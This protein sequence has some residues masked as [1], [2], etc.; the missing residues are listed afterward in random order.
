VYAT[1]LTQALKQVHPE[2]LTSQGNSVVPLLVTLDNLRGATTGRV[3][4]S[5]PVGA[6]VVVA[7][8]FTQFDSNWVW[9]FSVAE[10]ESIQSRIYVRLPENVTQSD[11]SIH[12]ATDIEGQY[13][14]QVGDQLSLA[15]EADPVMPVTLDQLDDL[16]WQY[17]YRL[18]YRDAYY[19]FKA[20]KVALEQ[21][22]LKTAQVLMITATSLLM[23]GSEHDVAVVRQAIDEHIRIV[24]Q[25]L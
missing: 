11:F 6:E 10:H 19:K 13:M 5:L 14:E 7:D 12:V 21:G 22:E 17:W 2:H 1:L 3:T 24:G 18:E 25:Q 16:A 9:D 23:T 15:V 4:L 8:S 20:A